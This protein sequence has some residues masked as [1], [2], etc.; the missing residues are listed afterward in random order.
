MLV[1]QVSRNEYLLGLILI[2][3]ACYYLF[4]KPE[5]DCGVKANIDSAKIANLVATK[6]YSEFL[7]WQVMI[8]NMRWAF[9]RWQESC[10]RHCQPT[11]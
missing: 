10:H 11:S 4:N 3:V 8:S 7:D 6:T 2:C 5:Q 1:T 9:M